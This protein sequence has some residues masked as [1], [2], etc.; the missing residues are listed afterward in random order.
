MEIKYPRKADFTPILAPTKQ[1]KA[2]GKV[3]KNFP[4]QISHLWNEMAEVNF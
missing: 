1:F 3:E 2:L 4:S